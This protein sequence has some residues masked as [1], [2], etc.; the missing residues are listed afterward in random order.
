MAF[1]K[2]YFFSWEISLSVSSFLISGSLI[3]VS[4]SFLEV[5]FSDFSS[6]DGANVSSLTSS[7]FDSTSIPIFFLIFS[8]ILAD[9]PVLSLK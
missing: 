1:R 5:T 6:T 9:L 4:L 7:G 2:N 3:S 8:V